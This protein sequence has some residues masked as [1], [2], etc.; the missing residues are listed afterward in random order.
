MLLEPVGKGGAVLGERDERLVLSRRLG[1]T[2]EADEDP[3]ETADVAL[4][5]DVDTS[6]L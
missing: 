4:P 1:L 6:T 5:A 3:A 2:R